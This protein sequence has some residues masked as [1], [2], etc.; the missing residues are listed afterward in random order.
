MEQKPY[1]SHSLSYFPHRK[2]VY[3]SHSSQRIHRQP[4]RP[5]AKLTPIPRTNHRAIPHI[6]HLAPL[7]EFIPAETLPRV[8]RPE[9]RVALAQAR[10]HLVRHA[11]IGE[12]RRGECSSAGAQLRPAPRE[13]V[14]AD[15]GGMVRFLVVGELVEG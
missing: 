4:I 6:R 1:I 8:L 7:C 15:G 2:T 11:I 10:T 5:S 13:G 9:K 3:Q 12:G 14:R